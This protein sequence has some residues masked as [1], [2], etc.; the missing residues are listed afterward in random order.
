MIKIVTE[1]KETVTYPA[2]E[3]FH[4]VTMLIQSYRDEGYTIVSHTLPDNGKDGII[5][6]EKV[7]LLTAGA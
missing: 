7:E 4:T 2:S 1:K 5:R 3:P 6:V